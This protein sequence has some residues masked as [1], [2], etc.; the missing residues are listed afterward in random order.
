MAKNLD[1]YDNVWIRCTLTAPWRPP[2][3][4]SSSGQH[5]RKGQWIQ[6]CGQR[7]RWQHKG[8]VKQRPHSA[9]ALKLLWLT[10]IAFSP[11]E[12]SCPLISVCPRPNTGSLPSLPESSIKV[13]KYKWVKDCLWLASCL[14]KFG[15]LGNTSYNWFWLGGRDKG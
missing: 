15:Y 12:S 14:S 2:H 5:F 4:V 9:P 1:W 3:I 13:W 11:K 7:S 8:I 10:L 6:R